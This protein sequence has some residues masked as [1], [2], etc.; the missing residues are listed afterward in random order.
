MI[1]FDNFIVHLNHTVSN[2]RVDADI[3]MTMPSSQTIK[4]INGNDIF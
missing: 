2:I 3:T 4:M 1:I